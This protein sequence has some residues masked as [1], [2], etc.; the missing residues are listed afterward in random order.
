MRTKEDKMIKCHICEEDIC[1]YKKD[2][3]DT[4]E[5]Y[6]L[7]LCEECSHNIALQRIDRN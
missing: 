2:V 5:M 4:V 6:G 3:E 1:K 7:Y